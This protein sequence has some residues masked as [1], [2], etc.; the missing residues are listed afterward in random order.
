MHKEL[1]EVEETGEDIKES[2]EKNTSRILKG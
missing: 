1:A 2:I